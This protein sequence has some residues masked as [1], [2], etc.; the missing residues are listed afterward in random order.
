[1]RLRPGI[2][3]PSP[4]RIGFPSTDERILPVMAR[5]V[6]AYASFDGVMSG[7]G[8]AQIGR[9]V[10]GLGARGFRYHLVSLEKPEQLADA[11]ARGG[12][13]ALLWAAGVDWTPLPY[14]HGGSGAMAQ[15]LARL[16][17]VLARLRLRG[18]SLVHARGYQSALAAAGLAMAGVPF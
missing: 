5:G 17:A 4:G 9:V 7:L 11:A 15:N 18:L 12:P 6:I 16:G 14:V 8:H 1:W 2:L 13:A 10:A 3:F